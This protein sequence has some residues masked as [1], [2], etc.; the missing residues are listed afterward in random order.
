MKKNILNTIAKGLIIILSII[1]FISVMDFVLSSSDSSKTVH[2]IT[3]Q[4]TPQNNSSE[5]SKKKNISNLMYSFPENIFGST[6]SIRAINIQELQTKELYKRAGVIEPGSIVNL[7]FYNPK[8]QDYRLLFKKP[9]V[10]KRYSH[11]VDSND[12][13]QTKIVYEI[14]TFDSN[15]DGVINSTDNAIL[16]I[17]DLDGKELIQVTPDTV[18]VVE[19]RFAEKYQSIIIDSKYSPNDPKIDEYLW[20]HKQFWYDISS[21]QFKYF[22]FDTLLNQTKKIF[23]K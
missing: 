5:N 6:Y 1:G 21:K 11:P 12:L 14:N 19:Y 22:E 10:V 20:P 23:N 17:S 2:G 8:M 16:F 3:V 4:N 9:V 7:V 18:S 13:G 15:K